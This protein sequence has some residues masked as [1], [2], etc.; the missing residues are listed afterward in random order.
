MIII[1]DNFCIALFSGVPKLTA[2]YHAGYQQTD[3]RFGPLLDRL[4][5]RVLCF[6]CL[7]IPDKMFSNS[8]RTFILYA[9]QMSSCSF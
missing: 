1:I 3:S 2:L 8:S 7:F 9:Y 4:K 6:R 5:V